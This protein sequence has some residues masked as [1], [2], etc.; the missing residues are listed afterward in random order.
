VRFFL[1]RITDPDSEPVS[2]VEMRQQVREFANVTANDVQYAS[3]IKTAREWAEDFTGR[4]LIDQKWRLTLLGRSGSYAGGDNVYGTRDGRL[5]VGYGYYS[6]LMQTGRQGE[7]ALYKS[8]ALQVTS[9]VTV[10]A[11]GAEADV[12]AAT[13]EL[14]DGGAKWPRLVAL[15]GATWASWLTGDMRIEYRAGFIDQVGSPSVGTVPERFRQAILLYAEAL[16]DRDE[17][18]IDRL[19][20]AATNLIRPECVD[21][22]LA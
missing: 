22:S 1:E 16:Y 8:P 13:Y 11:A 6:G 10:D 18:M 4:A 3:L 21:L 9:F 5:P 19:I 14:R 7:I 20:S 12:D 15:N 17:K 2:L